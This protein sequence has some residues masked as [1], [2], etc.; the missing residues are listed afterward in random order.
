VKTNK[1]KNGTKEEKDL[2][3][4]PKIEVN[5]DKL[6]AL[7]QFKV[8]KDFCADYLGVSPEVIDFRIKEKSGLTFSE[9]HNLKMQRTGLKLQQKAIEM[10]IAGNSALMIFSLKNLSKWSDKT[11]DEI[12]SDKN[13]I[14]LNY[15]LKGRSNGK[16]REDRDGE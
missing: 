10:A 7:L 11:E 9:Y 8:S 4:R 15:N 6:D 13:R 1:K 2:G 16:K 5:F 12:E 14:V 3:G